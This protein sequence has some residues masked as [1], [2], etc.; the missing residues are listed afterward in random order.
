MRGWRS[1]AKRPYNAVGHYTR[2][3][4]QVRYRLG[5]FAAK[6]RKM[7]SWPSGSSDSRLTR[8]RIPPSIFRSRVLV[9]SEF[10]AL[11]VVAYTVADAVSVGLA[12][13]GFLGIT[14]F[15]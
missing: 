1:G 2:S 3:Q 9:D 5:V 4:N 12:R 14:E 11:V 13:V 15:R 7:W 10:T 6:M 8:E